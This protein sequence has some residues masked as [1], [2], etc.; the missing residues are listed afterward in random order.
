[1]GNDAS[2]NINQ[3]I[4]KV[5]LNDELLRS[6][7]GGESA[8][9]GFSF[10]PPLIDLNNNG[11]K[12]ELP[13]AFIS[14]GKVRTRAWKSASFDGQSHDVHLKI[15]H[16]TA[17]ND[18]LNK[19]VSRLITLFHDCELKIENHAVVEFQFEW[20]ETAELVKGGWQ[21]EICFHALTVSD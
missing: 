20:S 11:G 17:C 18:A 15:K 6:C 4:K 1:M 8:N 21:A 14:I 10:A 5:I 2:W 12:E 3:A 19:A 13:R 16:F 7:F 9:D